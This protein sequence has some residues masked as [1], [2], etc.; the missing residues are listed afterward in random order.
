[1]RSLRSSY[2]TTTAPAMPV[3][4]ADMVCCIKNHTALFIK[5]TAFLIYPFIIKYSGVDLL[6]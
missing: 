4:Y 1:M 6:A 3:L 2:G 5:D